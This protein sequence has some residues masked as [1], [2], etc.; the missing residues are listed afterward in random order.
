MTAAFI[1]S[2]IAF[3]VRYYDEEMQKHGV[4]LDK[5]VDC[6]YE[7]IEKSTIYYTL[8]EGSDV[9][10]LNTRDGWSYIRRVDGKIG[11]VKSA[12]IGEV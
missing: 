10:I 12:S 4:V 3:G 11:W 1:L 2:L 6:R 8:P 7:P 9:T 5:S